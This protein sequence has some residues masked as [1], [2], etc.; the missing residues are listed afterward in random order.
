VT[1]RILVVDDSPTI[2][3]VVGAILERRGFQAETARDGAAGLAKLEEPDPF[4]LV[5]VDFV[6]PKMNGFQFCRELRRRP[7]TKSLPVVLMS[8]KSDR[9]RQQFVE[10]TGALDAISKP[11]DA[12]S[13]VLVIEG[14][15]AKA[16][17]GRTQLALDLETLGDEPSDPPASRAP[18]TTNENALRGL[19]GHLANAL[20]AKGLVKDLEAT[21][22]ELEGGLAQTPR[23]LL[24]AALQS[25]LSGARPILSGD[26]AHVSLAEVMQLLQMQKQSGLL[27]VTMKGRTVSLV[28]R[29]GLVDLAETEGSRQEFR[30]GRY[31]VEAGLVDRRD[32]EDLAKRARAAGRRIGEE[33]VASGK[34]TEVARTQALVR[35]TSEIIYDLVRWQAGAFSFAPHPAPEAAT[36]AKLGLGVPGLIFEG[37]RRVDEWRLMEG[38]IVW[39]DVII[40]DEA[41]LAQVQASLTRP[42]RMVVDAVDGRRVLSEIV[43]ACE[44]AQFDALKVLFQLKSS[45]VLRVLP[46]AG[47]SGTESKPVDDSTTEHGDSVVS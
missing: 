4:D 38:S 19:G 23:A 6:M 44:L 9:I 25:P 36:L 29:E 20:L 33:L 22:R 41:A 42:E 17:A 15:L 47:R 32:V 27:V 1:S 34:V 35:Q 11:F 40:V 24:T 2:L 30:L 14:A 37:F 43:D 16:K 28:F 18:D 39:E 7:K 5:L 3:K 12:R 45:R 8:A 13:L 26:L 10:Q 21:A 31:F 46:P